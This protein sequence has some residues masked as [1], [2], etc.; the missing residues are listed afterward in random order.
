[1]S[2]AS[3]LKAG[4]VTW[5]V[6]KHVPGRAPSHMLQEKTRSIRGVVRSKVDVKSWLAK[7][8]TVSEARP[9]QCPACGS[10]S[11]PVGEGLVLHGHG[12]RE[13]QLWGPPEL[14]GKPT[15][16]IV[17]VRRY[18]CQR[19]RAV[20][21]VAPAETLTKRLYTAAAIGWA[22]ALYGLSLLSPKAVRHLVSPLRHWGARSAAGWQ[23]LRRWAGAAAAGRLFA[24]VGPMPEEW[25]ARKVAA[26]AATTLAGHAL[27]SPEPPALEVLSFH[28]AAL[29]R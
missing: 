3:P 12:L 26:R 13:R 8:P 16:H 28:G 6:M 18:E 7:T 27:P 11:R 25:S 14:P 10:A 19:C 15:I 9:A 21:V 20:T 5:D 23:T 1:M 17:R 24:C 29:A 2:A 4:K 22:L